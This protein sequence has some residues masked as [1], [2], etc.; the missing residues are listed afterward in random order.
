MRQMSRM[1]KDVDKVHEEL[2]NRYVAASVAGDL[3]E[4]TFN[5]QQDMV[6]ISIDPKALQ[7][8][9]DGEVDVEMLEDMVLAA[10]NAGIEKAKALANEEM[11]G[12]TGGMASGFPGLF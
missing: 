2:K 12:A 9:D 8:G 1:R 5:G 10:V 7:R 3:I 11:D 4:V 6:K